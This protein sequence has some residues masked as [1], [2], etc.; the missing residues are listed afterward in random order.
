M[1]YPLILIAHPSVPASNVA[2]L[3]ALA[4][5]KPL[6]YASFGNG[7]S[8][9]LGTELLK[10]MTG[11]Q[12]LHVPYKG[13]TPA[14]MDLMSGQVSVMFIDMPP[15]IGQIKSGRIKVLAVSS[16]QRSPLLPEVPSVSE[17]VPGFGFDS[18]AGLFAP[19]GTPAAVIARLHD[20]VAQILSQPEIKNQL[21]GLGA[22]PAVNTPQQFA[23]MIRSETTKW[24]KVVKDSGAQLD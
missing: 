11:T 9:H 16:P 22:E 21:S 3:L 13:G 18:W 2:E 10:S 14:L 8:P 5:T 24:A 15:A 20:E 1:N 23:A 6:N 4:K 19:A 17:T 7:S 12:L